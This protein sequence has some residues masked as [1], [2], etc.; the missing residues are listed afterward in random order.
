MAVTPWH[1]EENRSERALICFTSLCGVFNSN[2]LVSVH[3]HY[4]PLLDDIRTAQ[5][6]ATDPILLTANMHVLYFL[7]FWEEEDQDSVPTVSLGFHIFGI[8]YWV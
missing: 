5:L 7:L 6:C 2:A 8:L 3:I 1:S 4:G